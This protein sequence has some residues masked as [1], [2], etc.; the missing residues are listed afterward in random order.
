MTGTGV[1]YGKAVEAIYF[2]NQSKPKPAVDTAMKTIHLV[3]AVKR[4]VR[5]I[6]RDE[7]YFR[8][9]MPLHPKYTFSH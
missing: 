9:E 3:C 8:V 6:P 7:M 5:M 1:P 4:M 2:V